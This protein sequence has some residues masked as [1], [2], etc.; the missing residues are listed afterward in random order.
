MQ[1]KPTIVDG[2]IKIDGLTQKF[3]ESKGYKLVV[4]PAGNVGYSGE[5]VPT[6]KDGILT[7][8][9][10]FMID[11]YINKTDDEVLE[12]SRSMVDVEVT[13]VPELL[14]Y[15]FRDDEEP[16][17]IVEPEPTPEPEPVA[18]EGFFS[19]YYNW[20]FGTTPKAEVKPEQSTAAKPS[21]KK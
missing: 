8:I 21:F 13:Y 7:E 15:P 12:L 10:E 5:K 16:E 17:V 14:S 6:T 2:K 11:E 19:S 4:D 20:I 18:Q 9:L 1:D 3:L